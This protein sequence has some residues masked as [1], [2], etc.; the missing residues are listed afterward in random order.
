MRINSDLNFQTFLDDFRRTKS[1][2]PEIPSESSTTVT[3]N[4]T[5]SLSEDQRVKQ[6]SKG[7]D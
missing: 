2:E 5:L 7:P 3:E 1:R 6:P 4:S